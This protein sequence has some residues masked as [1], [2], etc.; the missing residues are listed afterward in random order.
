MLLFD[1]KRIKDLVVFGKK[2]NN[3]PE[4][5]YLLLLS[6]KNF[7]SFLSGVDLYHLTQVTTTKKV[8]IIKTS[9]QQMTLLYVYGQNNSKIIITT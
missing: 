2:T 9:A 8:K 1:T 7:D 5:R 3:L 6:P 4:N